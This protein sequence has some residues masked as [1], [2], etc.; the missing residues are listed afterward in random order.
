[1]KFDFFLHMPFSTKIKLRLAA[2]LL[3]ALIGIA[4][5]IVSQHVAFASEHVKGFYEGFSTGLIGAGI[6]V[7]ILQ[8]RFLIDK[9]AQK[10]REI[11]EGD[12]RN[13]FI[14][15]QTVFYA[16]MIGMFGLC[17]AMPISA[18]YSEVILM[19]LYTVFFAQLALYL[20]LYAV[21][22]RIR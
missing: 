18:W 12:E 3:S 17:I 16:W 1:M 6:A 19:T 10:K 13:R 8:I 11:E 22:K 15:K 9:K 21:L 4:G 7:S 2:S 20:I 14:Y 5:L